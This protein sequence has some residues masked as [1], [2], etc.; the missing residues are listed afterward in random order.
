VSVPSHPRF[1][2]SIHAHYSPLEWT[3]HR[4][5][6]HIISGVRFL[7]SLLS[8]LII[9]DSISR[10]VRKRH[11]TLRKRMWLAWGIIALGVASGAA[12]DSS[13]AQ[14]ELSHDSSVTVRHS[15]HSGTHLLKP[16]FPRQSSLSVL[17]SLPS[18]SHTHKVTRLYKHVCMG[19]TQTVSRQGAPSGGWH[20]TL[21]LFYVLSS[22][23]KSCLPCHLRYRALHQK[24]IQ[25]MKVCAVAFAPFSYPKD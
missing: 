6:R 14:A 13:P 3:R 7:L 9:P 4:A 21:T 1:P 12:Q 11:V 16:V 24:L 25:Q 23:S 5:L 22:P 2:H 10:M 18:G 15:L 8:H 17:G 19:A 20:V